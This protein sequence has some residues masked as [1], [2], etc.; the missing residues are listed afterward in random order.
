MS[1]HR[2]VIVGAGLA[3]LTVAKAVAR[4]PQRALIVSAAGVITGPT[5]SR[6]PQSFPA[7]A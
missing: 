6:P 4:A 7:V 1:P 5:G 3:G 2:V